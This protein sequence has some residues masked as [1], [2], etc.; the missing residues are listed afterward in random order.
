M[1]EIMTDNSSNFLSL[2]VV[3]QKKVSPTTCNRTP[4]TSCL[5]YIVG[6]ILS[7]AELCTSLP[8]EIY[9]SS[10]SREAADEHVCLALDMKKVS[11]RELTPAARVRR[12]TKAWVISLMVK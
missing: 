7:R 1:G 10:P 11:P 4:T 12:K 2:E 6:K 8:F 9:F 5:H 3:F